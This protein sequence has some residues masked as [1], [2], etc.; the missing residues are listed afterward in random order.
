[1]PYYK[2]LSEEELS[3]WRSTL[4]EMMLDLNQNLT[5]SGFAYF[6]IEVYEYMQVNAYY[7]LNK[8]SSDKGIFND[9]KITYKS[10]KS[11][12]SREEDFFVI[13]KFKGIAD[14]L[15]HCG[16]NKDLLEYFISSVLLENPNR[17]RK[18]LSVVLKDLPEV[19]DYLC[20]IP[21]SV[22]YRELYDSKNQ[23]IACKRLIKD[24]CSGKHV[25]MK[26]LMSYLQDTTGLSKSFVSS[27]I[28]DVLNDVNVTIEYY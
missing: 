7:I 28:L 14:D 15:R 1:M 25:V 3:N 27:V 4:L 19:V 26:D 12:F 5:Y 8:E 23:R 13:N 20:G 16:Q 11:L 17:C 18:V 2:V 22:V 24:Y 9:I 10:L 21:M 6:I